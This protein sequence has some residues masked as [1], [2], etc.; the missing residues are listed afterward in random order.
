MKSKFVFLVCA[1]TGLAFAEVGVVVDCKL[2][3][4]GSFQAKTKD[5]KGSVVI[6]NNEVQADNISVNLKTLTTEMPLRDDHMKNKYLEVDKYP[7]ATLILGKGKDGKGE[8]KIKIK[9]VEHAVSGT[10]KLVSDNE[11]RAEF[12]IN[13]S[14]YKISGI[15]YL[16]VGVK[17]Q[18]KIVVNV[19]VR[20][21]A[22]APTPAPAQK[23]APKKK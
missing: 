3:P 1:W 13:L 23:A 9:G 16:S 12:D 20:K 22:A 4:M 6:K 21:E 11:L 2:S 7:D 5:V 19:P 8:G 14:D 18:A 17:D 10:Y 15:R